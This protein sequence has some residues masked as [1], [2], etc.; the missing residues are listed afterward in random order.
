MAGLLRIVSHF[1]GRLRV[2]AERFRESAF[3]AEVAERVRAEGGVESAAVSSR[4]GSLLVE[5]R[6][7]E[8]QLPRLV[9]A[10]LR[11]AGLDGISADRAPLGAPQGA[12]LR[13]AVHRWNEQL[14][15]ASRG[16]VDARTAVPGTLASLGVLTLLFGSRR[17]PEWYDLLFWSF[18]TF[19][20]LNP[21]TSDDGPFPR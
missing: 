15:D 16:R 2:R 9:E 12:A 7:R 19:V 6:A 14:V 13:D 8:V 18:V 10:I 5:Y 20:N 11:I 21:P 3:G 4:T 1:P 17:L